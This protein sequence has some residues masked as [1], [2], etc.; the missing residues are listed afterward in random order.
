MYIQRIQHSY[1]NFF[2]DINNLSI[3]N[4]EIIGLVGENGSGKTTLMNI[5]SGI[6]APN[7]NIEMDSFDSK[8]IL[9]I[10]SHLEAYDFLTVIDFIELVL[11]YSNSQE[12]SV[13][14]IEKMGV[15][16]KK[17]ELIAN[18][19]QGM[20]KKLTFVNLFI[21]TYDFIILD[22][23]FNSVDVKYIAQMKNMLKEKKVESTILIS[24]HIL[25][26]LS[27]MC[28]SFIYLENGKV[29]KTFINDHDIKRLESEFYV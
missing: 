4:N 23:P 7:E 20:Q 10:P 16:D 22:E 2:L 5:L 27:D 13:K 8:K 9:Y 24:S 6:M 19:S 15:S 21:D 18:L 14:I 1:S 3:N 17:N 12:S 28:D 11:K 25:D 26:T 29:K